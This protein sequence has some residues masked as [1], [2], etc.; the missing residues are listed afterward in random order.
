MT[1]RRDH[2]R[3]VGTAGRRL[4]L[5]QLPPPASF[6]F[7]SSSEVLPPGSEIPASERLLLTFQ[8]TINPPGWQSH[9]PQDASAPPPGTPPPPLAP[10]RW[11]FL[12]F[13]EVTLVLRRMKSNR[14]ELMMHKLEDPGGAGRASQGPFV[15]QPLSHFELPS[16]GTEESRNKEEGRKGEGGGEILA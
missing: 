13:L 14:C 6:S 9:H 15:T 3:R 7:F 4:V 11:D 10:G 12:S 8:R 16:T 2:L 5:V 1:P